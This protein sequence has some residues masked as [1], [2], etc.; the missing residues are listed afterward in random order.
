MRRSL[1]S[2]P[3][4]EGR[5]EDA[6]QNM[7]IY[8]DRHADTVGSQICEMTDPSLDMRAHIVRKKFL[9]WQQVRQP[10][11]DHAASGALNW[12]TGFALSC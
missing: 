5:W 9:A 10:G 3:G 6:C 11:V 4:A 12:T 8:I 2:G 7:W 1:N